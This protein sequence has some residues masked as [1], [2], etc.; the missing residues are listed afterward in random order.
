MDDLDE[1]R[2]DVEQDGRLVRRELDR[3]VLERGGWATALFLYQDLDP[4]TETWKPAKLTLMRFRRV[5]DQWRKHASFNLN[6][7]PQL[8][9]LRDALAAWF[10]PESLREAPGDAAAGFDDDDGD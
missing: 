7:G 8:D 10:P 3:R 6:G 5:R 9:L 2:F 1:L 4:T